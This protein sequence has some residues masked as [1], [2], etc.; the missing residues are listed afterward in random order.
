MT[1]L[2]VPQRVDI[3]TNTNVAYKLVEHDGRG[4]VGREEGGEIQSGGG[5]G[6]VSHEY[7]VV[8]IPCSRLSPQPRPASYELPRPPMEQP[9]TATAGGGGPEEVV[10]ETM[11]GD[12]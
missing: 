2:H 3:T 11:S 10:Y 5:G 6:G 4:N 8:N 1:A 12:Q 9:A 7:D